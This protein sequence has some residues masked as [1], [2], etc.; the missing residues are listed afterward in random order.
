MLRVALV[1]GRL[2]I[3]GAEAELVRLARGLDRARFSP[4]VVTLQ[5]AGP[6][7]RDLG[8]VELV[9]LGR[10]RKWSPGTYLA[11]KRVLLERKPDI[12]QSFLF[13]ENI[14]CRRI[15]Q[16]IV[17]SGLQGSL[18]DD[19]ETGPSLKLTLERST[20]DKAA[21]VVSNSEY[22]RSLYGKLGLDA[23]KIRVIRSAVAPT[24]ASGA[25]VREHFGIGPA[26]VL[27]T[28]VA[29]LV[30]RKGHEDLLRA[31]AGYKLLFVGD[32]PMRRRLESRGAI[33]AGAR[34]DVA[35][36]LAASDIV[37]LPSRFGEGCPNAL[38]EAMA[39]GK[40]VIAARSGGTPEVVVDGETGLLHPPE[41]VDALR[42]ALQRLAADPALRARLGA[43]GRE[44]AA[45]EFG[46]ERLVRDYETLYSELTAPHA[47]V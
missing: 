25:G 15:G 17:V 4:F 29:R 12:V 47:P 32:G 2:N 28:V 26:E 21:A 22:Y 31:A 33:L 42:A 40:P 13:T 10:R 23:R 14:F 18:S 20:F 6:L 5:D 46:V 37:A 3:G 1:I 39:A 24:A 35:E 7:A 44:R 9:E 30:E 38:L 36:I 41:D 11:L 16:G 45:R 19:Y 34:R 8:D 43:A 27:T